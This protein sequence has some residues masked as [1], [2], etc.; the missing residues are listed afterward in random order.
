M[1]TRTL[2]E[3]EAGVNFLNRQLPQ[4]WREGLI[5]LKNFSITVSPAMRHQKLI[6]VTLMNLF[7]GIASFG[8]DPI[9]LPNGLSITP[10]AAPRSVLFSLNPHMPERKDVSMGEAVTTA[11][12]P[13]GQTLLVLTSGYNKEGKEKFRE[14]VFIFDVSSYP[15]RQ[16]DALPI[17]N[18]FCG[19]AWNPNG[20]EFY[21]SGGVDDLMYIF[22]KSANGKFSRTAGISLGHPRGNGLYS[23][24]SAPLDAEAPKP[25]VAGIGVNQAGEIAVVANFY[26]DSISIIDIESRKKTG[27]LT[28]S[29]FDHSERQHRHNRQHAP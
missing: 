28:P 4:K 9:R 1:I 27:E 26:N 22:R 24:L 8:S 23:N 15:P 6:A 14:Y 13:N 29:F 10:D 16:V 2:R 18:S 11:L 21:V 20:L 25:M 12:S 3:S 19:L 7:T 5:I 17:P